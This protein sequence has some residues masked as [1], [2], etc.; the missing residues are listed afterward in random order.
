MTDRFFEKQLFCHAA[1]AQ[2]HKHIRGPYRKGVYPSSKNANYFLTSLAC[3]LQ[4]K[5]YQT[6]SNEP[7]TGLR[8]LDA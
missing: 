1:L 4:V 3:N 8:Q 7:I 5:P 2:A 6:E